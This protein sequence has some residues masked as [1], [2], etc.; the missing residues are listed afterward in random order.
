MEIEGFENY[1]IYED[2]RVFSKGNKFNKPRFLKYKDDG[3][4]YYEVNLYKDG[5]PKHKKI[6]RLIAE[7][8]IPNPHNYPCIDHIDR[9]RK[10]NSI[11]NLRWC[12]YATN[13]QNIGLRKDN[14]LGI[15]N[16]SKCQN[17]G[18]NFEKT[19]NGKRHRKWFKTLEEAIQYKDEYLQRNNN[20]IAAN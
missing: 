8:Y 4:G 1:L 13:N 10:N 12:S 3:H 20:R 19:I 17:I 11:N 14:K 18:Y 5:K 7:H 2:G 16:I 9:D 6:H 15:K